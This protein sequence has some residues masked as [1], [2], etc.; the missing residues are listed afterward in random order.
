MQAGKLI[1]SIAVVLGA[2][3]TSGCDNCKKLEERTHADLGP[4]C[5]HWKTTMNLAGVPTT[6]RKLNNV[7]GNMPGTRCAPTCS[8]AC[9]S[10]CRGR[11]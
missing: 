11:S 9:I 5:D 6:G 10:Y 3:I 2:F 4:D 8:R 1:L 7:C